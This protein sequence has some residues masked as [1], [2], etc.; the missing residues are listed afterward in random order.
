MPQEGTG[1]GVRKAG[2]NAQQR[3]LTATRGTEQ[4]N[5]LSR[6]DCQVGRTHN[7][8]AGAVRLRIR[9]LDRYGF[10]NRFTHAQLPYLLYT[11]YS[12][13]CAALTSGSQLRETRLPEATALSKEGLTHLGR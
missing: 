10:D 9:L 4:G 8:D 11:I 13:K 12:Q 7:L 5:N 6:F 3:G 1:A 2:Q